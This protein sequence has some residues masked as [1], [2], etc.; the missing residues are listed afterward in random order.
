MS[1]HEKVAIITGGGTGI[2]FG[3]AQVLSEKGVK[4]VLAQ[5]RLD[6]AQHAVGRL[7]PRD[8]AAALVTQAPRFVE[9]GHCARADKPAVALEQRQIVSERGFEIAPKFGAISAQPR[10]GAQQLGRE[11]LSGLENAGE[12][13]RDHAVPG[14]KLVGSL[15]RLA[16]FGEQA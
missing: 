12:S 5:R 15:G 16:R 11:V 10:I 1:L 13:P 4:V 7:Q 2:G 14:R 3:I 9:R 6:L 8:H